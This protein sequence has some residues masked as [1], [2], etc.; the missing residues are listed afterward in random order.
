MET[1]RMQQ[2]LKELFARGEI[3]SGGKYSLMP[4]DCRGDGFDIALKSRTDESADYKI[5]GH[6][7]RVRCVC[8]VGSKYWRQGIP[9]GYSLEIDPPVP[10]NLGPGERAVIVHRRGNKIGNS[11]MARVYASIAILDSCGKYIH[12]KTR[13]GGHTP[14]W[15]GSTNTYAEHFKSGLSKADSE[16]YWGEVDLLQ[17]TVDA[18]NAE[19]FEAEAFALAA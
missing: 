13:R 11:Y 5:N 4:S 9:V 3:K 10:Y 14:Y 7:C 12:R 1:Q 19:K 16:A 2:K 8:K 18:I 17:C 15:L 6:L